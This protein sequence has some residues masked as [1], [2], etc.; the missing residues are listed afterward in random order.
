MKIYLSPSMQQHNIYATNNTNEMVQCNRIAE[1]AEIALKRCGFEVKRAKQ[2]Q[3]MNAS[4]AESNA[5][6]TDLHIPIHTNAGGGSGTLVM[7]YANNRNNFP[8]AKSIYDSVNAV[9]PGTTNYGVR[10]NSGLAELNSTKATAVY[11]ECEF[12]D[13]KDLAEWII[14]NVRTIGEAICKGVC[15]YANVPY[16]EENTPVNEVI[17]NNSDVLYRVQVGAFKEKSNAEKLANELKEKGY[18]TIIK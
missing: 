6:S 4:I 9:T 2:G 7:I 1:Y 12:H 16:I 15:N 10:V 8:P 17:D 18:N 14:D 5:W 13:R 3:T 11:I